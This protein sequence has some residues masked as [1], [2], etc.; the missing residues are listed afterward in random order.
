[1][2]SNNLDPRAATDLHLDFT[3]TGLAAGSYDLVVYDPP[4]VADGGVSGIMTQRYGSIRTTSALR[5]LIEAGA[6]E[7]WRVSSAGVIVKVTEHHHGGRF[8]DQSAWIA[9]ALGVPLYTKL[10]TVRTA[11][12]MS[13]GR[14]KA[15]RVPRSNGAVYLV[16]RHDGPAHIDFDALY[17]RQ[18]VGEAKRNGRQDLLPKRCPSCFAL[19]DPGR[20]ADAETCT[21]ACRLRLFRA[22]RKGAP[23]RAYRRQEA[24]L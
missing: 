11:G 20:R 5:E 14:W 17:R 1:V 6:R 9:Q 3:A 12:L 13:S 15:E 18:E 24:T 21:L 16:Y 10:S 22:R 19:L 23:L 7:A 4:H 2:T 8:L